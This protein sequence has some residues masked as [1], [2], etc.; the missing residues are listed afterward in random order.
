MPASSNA[1]YFRLG[2]RS[3]ADCCKMFPDFMRTFQVLGMAAMMLVEAS[4]AVIVEADARR[5][6]HLFGTE[7]CLRCHS[8]NGQGGRLGPDLSRRMVPHA[9][10]HKGRR[11]IAVQAP[12]QI[13][14]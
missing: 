8:I 2:R 9:A 6:A 5:G 11:V 14:P 3:A 7:M 1:R 10:G 4:A 13:G 12:A